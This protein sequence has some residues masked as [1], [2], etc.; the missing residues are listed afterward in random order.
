MVASMAGQ[1]LHQAKAEKTT[2]RNVSVI[3]SSSQAW[4]VVPMKCVMDKQGSMEN[5][6]AGWF[7]GSHSVAG[8]LPPRHPARPHQ[9]T[10]G[11]SFFVISQEI[12]ISG[13]VPG[14]ALGIFAYPER[15]KTLM[16][17]K[18]ASLSPQVL[19]AKL[20]GLSPK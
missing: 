17:P 18:P 10:E 20:K 7:A 9:M 4:E 11:S 19:K 2:F 1:P 13:A 14:I 15:L 6:L 3:I 5:A 12:R 8:L 16:T